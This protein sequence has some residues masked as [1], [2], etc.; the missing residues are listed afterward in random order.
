VSAELLDFLLRFRD[1]AALRVDGGQVEL[2][3]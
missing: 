1:V 2:D 3:F